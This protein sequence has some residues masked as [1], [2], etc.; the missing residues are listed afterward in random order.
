M[1]KC[2]YSVPVIAYAALNLGEKDF[3]KLGESCFN[4]SFEIDTFA[5]ETGDASSDRPLLNQIFGLIEQKKIITLVIPSLDHVLGTR[6]K[7]L[8]EFLKYLEHHC[9][10]LHSLDDEIKSPMIH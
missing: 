10:W 1:S 3:N 8:S 5:E 9:V 7:K 4:Q 2:L 6:F